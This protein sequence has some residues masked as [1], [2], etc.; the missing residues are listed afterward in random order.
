MPASIRSLASQTAIYGVS[1]ILSKFLNFLLTPYLTRIMTSG[2]YGEVSLL[3]GM[4]PFVNVLLT[5]GLATAY[6]RWAAKAETPFE[7][8]RIFTT[9]WT[10]VSLAALSFFALCTT[11]QLPISHVMGYG[12]NT[13]YLV[14]TAALIAVD[15]IA[16]I[17]LAALRQQGRAGR[18]TMVNVTSV[19][20]NVAL[21][22]ALYTF[23][24][25][26]RQS[27]GWVL[28]AN[29]AASTV[30]LAI[31]LPTAAKLTAR[32]FSPK[33]LK[34]IALYSFPLM[35]AGLM[36]VG[37]DF[38]DRQMLRWM[39][40]ADTGLAQVGIYGAVAKVAALMIIFR[41]IY[42][43]GAEPFFL[44]NFSKDDFKRMNACALKFFTIAGIFALLGI[45]FFADIFGMIIGPTFRSGMDIVPILLLANLLMG[46]LVNLSFWYK[47]ADKTH[48]AIYVTLGGFLTVIVGGYFL[49]PPYGYHGAAY[50]HLLGAVVMVLMSYIFNQVNYKVPY[51][52]GRIGFYALLG[53][54]LYFAGEYVTQLRLGIALS[55]KILLLLLFV[56][57]ALRLEKI[58]LPRLWK[59]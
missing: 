3:Y 50:S 30:S 48:Y 8:K 53:I 2:T 38:L 51:Q 49:I 45:T 28:V 47:V 7:Q 24:P 13:W 59:R 4:I 35:L 17:P 21:C 56:F 34:T 25:D 26:A 14:V 15:N 31:L 40:P 42:T 6:F 57:I 5:M 33:L 19:V 39:L 32:C 46:I 27:A 1:A 44:Q 54:A 58:N 29:L 52:M 55:V 37:S 36:G 11:F 18:Y 12:N 20:V 16:S 43:L 22:W 41:Q 9:L 23:I 10:T